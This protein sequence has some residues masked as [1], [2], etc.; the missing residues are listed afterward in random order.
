MTKLGKIHI[1]ALSEMNPSAK[2]VLV[3]K[4][5]KYAVEYAHQDYHTKELYRLFVEQ[6]LDGTMYSKE[7]RKHRA[8]KLTL[9]TTKMKRKKQK[10]KAKHNDESSLDELERK[11]QRRAKRQRNNNKG[12]NNITNQY[13]YELYLDNE[14]EQYIYE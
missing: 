6:D 2:I 4:E 14:A 12:Q 9:I 5:V 3:E 8:K 13:D 10:F 11:Q 7:L 1:Q